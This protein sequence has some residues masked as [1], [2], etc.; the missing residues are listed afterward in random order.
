MKVEVSVGEVLDKLSILTIKSERISDPNKRANVMKEQ[1][2]L[3]SAVERILTDEVVLLLNQLHDVNSKLWDIEDRIRHKEF[4][5]EF[6]EEF[7][8]L[9]RSVYHTNDIRFELKRTINRVCDSDLV[10]EKQH[11][12]YRNM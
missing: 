8:E 6:D 3:K 11:V 10:E 7:V 9:A 4:M 1:T 2:I 12:N 5:K